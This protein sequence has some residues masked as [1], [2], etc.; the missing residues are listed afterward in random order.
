MQENEKLKE[1]LISLNRAVLLFKSRVNEFLEKPSDQ[2]YYEASLLSLIQAFELSID[3]AS[4]CLKA[5]LEEQNY[6]E[7]NSPKMLF[8]CAADSDLISEA[9]IWYKALDLHRLI[10]NA[11]DVKMLK[12]VSDFLI[13]AFLPELLKL[14]KSLSSQ[15]NSYSYKKYGIKE[16]QLE[17]VITQISKYKEINEALLLNVQTKTLQNDVYIVLKANKVGPSFLETFKSTLARR[18]TLP[19]FVKFISYK[20][21]KDKTFLKELDE[22][23][24]VIYSK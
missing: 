22:Y 15:K 18:I 6:T 11:H 4:L 2:N 16:Y 10:R 17:A 23:G 5:F 20:Q 14:E 13:S 24:V 8:T 9:E 3:C 1:R 19:Y 7:L 21:L 12:G